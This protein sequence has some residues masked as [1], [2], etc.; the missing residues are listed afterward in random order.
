MQR[1]LDEFII[2][3]VKTTVDFHKHVLANPAFVKGKYATNF[4]EKLFEVNQ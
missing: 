3:P 4:V 1:A 2:D